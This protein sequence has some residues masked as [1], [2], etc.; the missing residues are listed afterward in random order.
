MT[1]GERKE[2]CRQGWAQAGADNSCVDRP[3]SHA[4]MLLHSG[5]GAQQVVGG[6]CAA[7]GGLEFQVDVLE[8]RRLFK[9]RHVQGP[10]GY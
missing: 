6:N 8:R 2:A 4:G 3:G 1:S 10:P 7:G 5:Q 9:D